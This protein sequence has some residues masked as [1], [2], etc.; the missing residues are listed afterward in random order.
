MEQLSKNRGG[1]FGETIEIEFVLRGIQRAAQNHGWSV[2][3]LPASPGLDLIFLTR[4]PTSRVA[5]PR[6]VYIS[7]GIHGDEPAGP[8][9]IQRL[10]EENA[11]PDDTA[12]WLAPCLNPTG[13]P[14]NTRESADGIDLNRDYL[15]GRSPEVQAHLR[16]LRKLPDCDTCFCLHEDW[17]SEGFYLY[18]LNPDSRPS[19]APAIVRAV[20][21][22]CPIESAAMIDGR[23]SNSPGIIRPS[24][25]PRLRLDWPEAF[26]LFQNLTRL[27]YTLESPSNFPLP[28]RVAALVNAI[29]AGLTNGNA[30]IGST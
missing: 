11:W 22:V 30:P 9:A 23:E 18:E 4:S 7:A 10:L 3:T 6:Q 5:R 28:V 20:R 27:S 2:E 8:V 13:F 17:E 12:L 21:P 19:L 29:H 25:D 14:R 16:W 26:W 1:Y 24:I 15:H